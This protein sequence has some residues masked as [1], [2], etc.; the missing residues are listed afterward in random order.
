MKVKDIQIDGFG[1][2]SNLSVDS[3][4]DTMTLFYGPNEAGKTTLMQFLRAMFYGFTPDRRGRYMPPVYGGTPG[5]SMRVTG[6]GGGYQIRRHSHATDSG[7][8]GQLSVTGQDGLAQ[9]QHRLTAL[10]G[11]IDEPIFT[12]VFAI[13]IR[14]L[15]ELSTL[16]DTSAADE[17]YKLSSGLDRV[18]LVDVMRSLRTGRKK[19]VGKSQQ[20]DDDAAILAALI[21]KREKLRDE[22]E[23][24]TRSGR[25]WS[26]LAT[27]RRSQAA[28]IDQLTER[29]GAWERESR[30]VEVATSVYN[31]WTARNDAQRQIADFE[32]KSVLPEDAPGQL[33]QIEAMMEERR[34]KLED[35]KAKR[36][37]LRAK[38]ETLPINRRLVD[39]QSKITAASEQATWLEALQDQIDRLEQQIIKAQQQVNAD[40]ERLGM[41]EEDREALL[42]GGE[43]SL[44]DL[45]RQTLAALAAPAKQ[46]KESLF[47]L[48]QS[49]QEAQQH[50]TQAEKL[51]ARLREMVDMAQA[52]NLHDA[53]RQQADVIATLRNRMQIEQHLEK[54]R[55]HYRDLE[56][57]SLELAT[58][59]AFPVERTILLFVPF[60]I[61][62]LGILYGFFHV[63]GWDWFSN[64]PDPTWGMTSIFVGVLCMFLWYIGR[65]RGFASTSL[66]LEDCER[67][68]DTLRRQIREV[69]T[70]RDALEG[71][72]PPSSAT[73][74]TRLRDAEKLHSDYEQA[75][76][77]YHSQQASIQAG[78]IAR[79]RAAEA[80]AALKEARRAWVSTLERL[81]LSDSLSPSS[82]RKL[83][84]GYETVQ[85]SR[86]RL[87]ELE[88]E[89][90]QR[91]REK[92]AIA[93]RI[94]A[95]YIEAMGEPE[96]VVENRP[97]PV[98]SF[99]S[100]KQK[101]KQNQLRTSQQDAAESNSN[102]SRGRRRSDP[103]EQLSYLQEEI[104]RSN[105]RSNAVSS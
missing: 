104:A 50:H 70:E 47:Q 60:L 76:P 89:R 56:K 68:I 49:R 33:I 55:R 1:V 54:L 51:G 41:D 30:C 7:V 37:E 75:L 10:L 57:E 2:W 78:K 59:E 14:E 27:Q 26:E 46:V 6:P 80:A 95:L 23:Q 15:Q 5:G 86:R 52:G 31:S 69:E 34:A 42:K 66:D 61:G 85:T 22:V 8:L 92:L 58:N 28:E 91:R 84:E 39:M 90:E 19:L 18:S 36:R 21:A 82:V 103:L 4:P 24:L 63:F 45:S 74:E 35:V 101:D 16:D 13:G 17:L 88:A 11:Q 25:R 72:L 20:S 67:Q 48:K 29:V 93:R 102:E 87:I 105:I 3:L 71:R 53:M 40:A 94:D 96:P 12:N 65:D 38:A 44:P 62:G 77:H 81:G 100:N 99:V 97:A 9:G 98:Q 79:N 83:S 43:S 64:D 32:N 73:L